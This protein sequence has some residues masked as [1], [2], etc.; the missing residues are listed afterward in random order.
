L[1]WCDAERKMCAATWRGIF[2]ASRAGEWRVRRSESM[3][4]RLYLNVME[5]RE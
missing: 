1:F 2:S 4:E 5:S 3:P